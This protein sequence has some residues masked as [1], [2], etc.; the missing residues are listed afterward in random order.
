M[1]TRLPI[2]RSEINSERASGVEL[3]CADTIPV[4]A[5]QWLW[6]GW[7]ARGKLHVLAGAPGTGKTTIAISFAGV[8]SMGGIWPD[9][10]QSLQGNVVVWSGEDD[11]ADTLVPRLISTG[12]DLGGIYFIGDVAD[13]RG[14]RRPF[15]PAVDIP[16]L[17]TEM[18]RVGNVVLLIVDPIVSAVAGDTHKN[19]E[20]RRALQPLADLACQLGT[21]VPGITH[22][23]K[24]STGRDPI[25]RVTGSIAF[26]AMARVVMVT[27]IESQADD[28]SRI[29]ARAKSNIGPDGGGFRYQLE[30]VNVMGIDA[31][32][33]TWGAAIEGKAHTLLDDAES[34]PDEQRSAKGSAKSWLRDQLSDRP[35]LSKEI[36]TAAEDA[37]ISWRTVERAKSEL[38]VVSKKTS[39]KGGWEWSL[40]SA[41]SE[42]RQ[43]RHETDAQ[44]AGGVGGVGHDLLAI[45][46]SLLAEHRTANGRSRRTDLLEFDT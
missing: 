42:G 7:L 37:G 45:P 16:R 30:Q 22:F 28:S 18:A 27:A 14:D 1:T 24:S 4:S 39:Q 31:S 6:R 3:V 10:A 40:P 11:P 35:R 12:A 46:D 23:S 13:A 38:G 36:E 17:Q 5:I 2:S 19:G 34:A 32:R 44:K 8:V 21:A 15:D 33:V 29:L 43:H 20:V 9:G 41:A 26:G 25:E